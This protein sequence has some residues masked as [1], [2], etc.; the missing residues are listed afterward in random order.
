MAPASPGREGEGSGDLRGVEEVVIAALGVYFVATGLADVIYYWGKIGLYQRY[1]TENTFPM[2]VILEG[3]F[4]GIISAAG[5]V[6]IGALLFLF[7][8]GVVA[9][10]RRLLSL[11]PL[12]NRAGQD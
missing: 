7:S 5:R 4:G 12:T 1:I 8:R 6:A 2:P 10:R 3:D 11:R 9:L